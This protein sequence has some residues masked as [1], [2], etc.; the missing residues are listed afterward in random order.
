M[1]HI[2]LFSCVLVGAAFCALAVGIA[3]YSAPPAAGAP[4][5][6]AALITVDS[7][8][9][10]VPFVTNGNCTLGEAIQAANTNAEIDGCAA[11]SGGDTIIVPAGVYTLTLVYPGGADAV[12]LPRVTSPLTLTGAL[13]STTILVRDPAAPQFRF[14]Q[15]QW[16]HTL[17]LN[18]LTMK[19]GDATPAYPGGAVDFTQATLIVNDCAFINNRAN[20]VGNSQGVGGAL[21]ASAFS[22][23]LTVNRS[24]FISNT[25]NAGGAIYIY[26]TTSDVNISD[27]AFYSNTTTGLQSLTRGSGGALSASGGHVL[28]IANST[29]E[30]NTSVLYG[31]AIWTAMSTNITASVIRGNTANGSGGGIQYSSSTA[32]STVIS[33]TIADNTAANGGGINQYN[34]SS[35]IIIGSIIS[36][37]TATV[38]SGGGLNLGDP[39]VIRNSTISGNSA[40]Y[41]GGG[42]N[43]GTPDGGL[44]LYNVT[45]T[46]NSTAYVSSA[47]G[48]HRWG[49]APTRSY[50]QNTIIAGNTNSAGGPPDCYA[51]SS[52]LVSNGYTLLGDD[53]GCNFTSGAGDIVGTGDSPIDPRLA[54]LGDYGGPTWTHPLYP[55]SPALE[56]GSPN[57]PGSGSDACEATDQRGVARPAGPRCDMGAYEGYLPLP[58]VAFASASYSHVEFSGPAA[59]TVTLSQA[60]PVTVTVDYAASPITATA[61][62]DF[63]PITGTL[64]F[65]PG[66]TGAAF[67]L[68]ILDDGLYE[69]DE[70]IALALSD[71]LQAVLGDPVSAPFSILND[72]PAPTVQFS[73]AGYEVFEDGGATAITVTLSAASGLTATVSYASSDDTATANSDYIPISGALTFAPGQTGQTLIVTVLADLLAETSET[74]ALALSAPAGAPLGAPAAATLTIHNTF[75]LFLPAVMR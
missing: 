25:A 51:N 22:S 47:G 2:K 50:A 53:S 71:P 14:L 39:T 69:A 70:T 38:G 1:S 29:F 4:A 7:T 48:L 5:A 45:L 32:V 46:G 11:G 74:V 20:E 12:G 19:N 17:T 62:S 10:E 18:N 34:A 64:T 61:G 33:S 49:S 66:V 24:V 67:A 30:G 60:W 40:P 35:L 58:D 26:P 21:G 31:G 3:L 54:P 57:S 36:G 15:V 16:P 68:P 52:S 13:S 41:Y 63:T 65:T 27:S 56:A 55:G 42:I 59:I 75:W 23:S 37:N 44:S 72:D 9:Q 8:A 6:P 28:N 73:S 43:D